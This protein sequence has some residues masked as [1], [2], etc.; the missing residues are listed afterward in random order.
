MIHR[1][2]CPE[3]NFTNGIAQEGCGVQLES[4]KIRSF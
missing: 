4:G 2:V 1:R 3:G